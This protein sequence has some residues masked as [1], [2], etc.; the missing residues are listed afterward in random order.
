M[1]ITDDVRALLWRVARFIQHFCVI[2]AAL[3]DAGIITLSGSDLRIFLGMAAA[4]A[5]AH[6]GRLLRRSR[7]LSATL[8]SL[9]WTGHTLE[10]MRNF[11][12]F[13]QRLTLV[14]ASVLCTCACTMILFVSY[15]TSFLEDLRENRWMNWRA[16]L[17]VLNF[18]ALLLNAHLILS[19][20][21]A[22]PLYWCYVIC[23]PILAFSAVL[24]WPLCALQD[25]F[26]RWRIRRRATGAAAR[27]PP[28]IQLQI[29]QLLRTRS[30]FGATEFLSR[31]YVSFK[32]WRAIPFAAARDLASAAR[33]CTAWHCAA[34]E[35]LY[36]DVSFR[37]EKDVIALVRTLAARPE[38]AVVV[39]RIL[40]PEDA[41]YS[42][43]QYSSMRVKYDDFARAV[44]CLLALCT[45]VTEVLLFREPMPLTDVPGFRAAGHLRTVTIYGGPAFASRRQD[46]PQNR[47]EVDLLALLQHF[48][49]LE[50]LALDVQLVVFDAPIIPPPMLSALRNIHTLRLG[51]CTVGM[52]ALVGL[53]RALPRLRVADL[54]H[55][56]FSA[57][58]AHTA[59]S[60]LFAAQLGTLTELTLRHNH[61][62]R[63][64]RIGLMWG[65]RARSKTGQTAIEAQDWPRESKKAGSTA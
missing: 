8:S 16:L 63:E 20:L 56:A 10:T 21:S 62:H 49:H 2:L 43:S 59:L 61:L 47:T 36:T 17:I 9:S 19:D 42:P 25:A 27:L 41:P 11:H 60:V 31:G 12:R 24:Y 26:A 51:E 15:K 4:G 22:T 54:R 28:E 34:T 23:M 30:R 33:V 38:L 46:D 6:F 55:V 5:I 50:S 45:G 1:L 32:S 39:R 53:L 44:D 7:A 14:S 13:S 35:A 58:D 64:S 40:L 37:H 3:R 65:R 52:A 18:T 57:A 29:F 48:P